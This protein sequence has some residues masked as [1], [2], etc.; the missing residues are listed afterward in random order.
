[1]KTLI[2]STALAAAMISPAFADGH[3]HA[4]AE[5][6]T[7]TAI[8]TDV[9]LTGFTDENE[10]V[11]KPV[12][13]E[14]GQPVGE[15]ER[16]SFNDDGM[17]GDIV[18]ETGGILEIGG[19]EILVTEGEYTVIVAQGDEDESEIRLEMTAEEFLDLPAFDEDLVSDYPLSDNDLIDG[20]NESEGEIDDQIGSSETGVDLET[21][22]RTDIDL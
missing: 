8:V 3:D 11:N 1:M 9:T 6:E 18:V 5:A 2:A 14:E 20:V 15:V 16:V 7:H 10:W 22:T 4:T 19:Q 17:V 12:F 21:G 13:D